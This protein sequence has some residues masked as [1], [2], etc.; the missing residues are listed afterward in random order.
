MENN[1]LNLLRLLKKKSIPPDKQKEI[2]YNIVAERT[3]KIEKC[4]NS[5]KFQNLI[6]PFK[7]LTKNIDFNNFMDDETF[8]DDIN[9]KKIG[10]EDAEK[11]QMEFQ[12]KLI[13]VRMGGNK[14]NKSLIQI[15]NIMNFYKW[16]QEVFISYNDYFKM[17]HKAAN[18]SKHG[19]GLKILTFKQILQRLPI[20]LVQV[21]AGNTSENLLNEICQIIYSLCLEKEITKKVYSNIMNSIKL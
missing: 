18:D 3:G 20:A 13:S 14:S 4:H 19:E 17:V 11:N 5:V 15:E 9:S 8:F 6:Y 7:G 2:F 12:S 21:K 1:Y 10:F 16:W